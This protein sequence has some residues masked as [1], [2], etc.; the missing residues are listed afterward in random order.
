MEWFDVGLLDE[1][2]PGQAQVVAAG[3]TNI[4]VI[5][6]DG[7]IYAVD[8]TCSHERFE[9]LGCGL[10]NDQLIENDQIICPRHG[11]RFDV[12]TGAALTPPAYEPLNCYPVKVEHGLI[13]VCSEK[14]SQ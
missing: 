1:L 14:V 5:N 8:N 10:Q 4:A 9:M 2:P 11:A 7:N 12:K 3:D 6:V 13:M